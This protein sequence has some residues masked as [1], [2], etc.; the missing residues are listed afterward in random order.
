MPIQ[1]NEMVIRANIREPATQIQ[2][3]AGNAGKTDV[4]KEEMIRECAALVLEMLN[5]QNAR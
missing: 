4:N 3:D 5:Q 2:P 1:I